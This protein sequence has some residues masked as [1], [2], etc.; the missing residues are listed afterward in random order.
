MLKYLLLL[1]PLMAFAQEK[2]LSLEDATKL[3]WHCDY[4]TTQSMLGLSE[5]AGCSVAYEKVKK[6]KFGGDYQK[7]MDWWKANK[8]AEHAKIAAQK[9][10]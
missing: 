2:P 7:F 1:F 10:G 5:A 6:E 3:F 4:A 8:A 9:N